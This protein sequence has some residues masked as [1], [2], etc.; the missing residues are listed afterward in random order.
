MSREPN[1]PQKGTP[2]RRTNMSSYHIKANGE[3]DVC[4]ATQRSCPLGGLHYPTLKEAVEAANEGTHD[5]VVTFGR[6]SGKPLSNLLADYKYC[7]G[8]SRSRWA[9]ENEPLV[10]QAV[11]SELERRQ[12]V[13]TLRD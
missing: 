5:P 6:Y 9:K 11:C 2:T 12:A 13:D 3:P 8:L 7:T 4:R 10:Y 1:R